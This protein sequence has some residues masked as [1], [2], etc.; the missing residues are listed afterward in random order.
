MESVAS[1]SFQWLESFNAFTPKAQ[2]KF[3]CCKFPLLAA[4]AYPDVDA[5]H[6]RLACDLMNFFFAF[7]EYTDVTDGDATREIAN[8]VVDI[9]RDP[10]KPLPESSKALPLGELTR[11]LWSRVLEY[12]I[13]SSA[14]R[15]RKSLE[16]YVLSCIVEARDRD[17]GH[18]RNIDDYIV[19][20]RRNSGARPT[21]YFYLLRVELPDEVFE[22]P[23][24]EQLILTGMDLIGIGND[25]YSYNMERS[26]G[27]HGHNMVTAVQSERSLDVQAAMTVV[28]DV[29][30]ETGQR[31]LDMMENLP[32]FSPKVDKNLARFAYDIASWYRGMQEWSFES[33]RY[34]GKVGL[35]VK[36][37]RIVQLSVP[38]VDLT[39]STLLPDRPKQLEPQLTKG[40]KGQFTQLASKIVS[41]FITKLLAPRADTKDAL[42]A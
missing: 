26:R 28:G 29:L 18:I 15:L 16:D 30:H 25:I 12:S 9:F 3:N 14:T 4:L 27:I 5:E 23:A 19:L 33:E 2:A 13:P 32:S 39:H 21:L 10:V 20:R 11:S 7:D 42:G 35:Q 36:E 40:P 41:H 1:A 31:Y 8:M 38:P 24:V 34:F 17:V 22:H 37:T 6:L